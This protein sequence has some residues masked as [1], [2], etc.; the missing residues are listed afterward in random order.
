MA[1]FKDWTHNNFELC[2]DCIK[3]SGISAYH[4]VL[5]DA[6]TGDGLFEIQFV[7]F[8]KDYSIG[9]YYP[10]DLEFFQQSENPKINIF[11]W[12][13]VAFALFGN[14][15]AKDYDDF[16]CVFSGTLKE[17]Q[18]DKRFANLEIEEN[19]K[20]YY[21][22]WLQISDDEKTYCEKEFLK[23]IIENRSKEMISA[24]Q[25]LLDGKTAKDGNFSYDDR[26]NTYHF[27][28][29][30]KRALKF[31]ANTFKL[32]YINDFE[33]ISS[34]DAKVEDFLTIEHT[35]SY[36]NIED[37]IDEAR[38]YGLTEMSQIKEMQ[39]FLNKIDKKQKIYIVNGYYPSKLDITIKNPET[40]L[41]FENLKKLRSDKLQSGILQTSDTIS[42]LEKQ[43]N[44]AQKL[45]DYLNQNLQ[46]QLNC[47]SNF[48]NRKERK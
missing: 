19:V 7:D 20:D 26:T 8:L 34:D 12:G 39:D 17:A 45:F 4:A 23:S 38:Q 22:S 18:A 5:F 3:N 9:G 35:T 33:V 36:Q 2:D 10:S 14:D 32:T 43:M 21:V 40:N 46:T 25:S 44:S 30:R 41:Y 47:H 27:G 1:L 37:F 29:S 28:D 24:L 48:N 11:C 13:E 15:Y 6:K 42:M 16:I 31:N